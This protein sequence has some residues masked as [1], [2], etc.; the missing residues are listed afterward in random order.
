MDQFHKALMNPVE[1][2]WLL[3]RRDDL[4]WDDVGLNKENDDDSVDYDESSPL[5]LEVTF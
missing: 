2:F 4:R 1:W 5:P 3:S